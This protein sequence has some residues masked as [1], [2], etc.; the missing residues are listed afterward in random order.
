MRRYGE[1]LE[2]LALARGAL[3]ERAEILRYI[4]QALNRSARYEE[5]VAPL[6]QAILK[7]PDYHASHSELG[8]ALLQTGRTVEAVEALKRALELNP[9]DSVATVNLIKALYRER[10]DETA[11]YSERLRDLKRQES[12]AA[13]AKVLSNFGL[14]AAGREEWES[15]VGQLREAVEVCGDCPIQAVLR[16]NLGLVLADSGEFPAALAELRAARSLDDHPDIE[17]ALGVVE[18]A[19]ALGQR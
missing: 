9:R 6:Q 13:R 14:A 19:A 2:A 15:A 16:K 1:A 7:E 17:Y 4:G 11:Q 5:A 3:G 12:A 10:S 18:R 8:L